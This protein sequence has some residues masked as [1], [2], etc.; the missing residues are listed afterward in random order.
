MTDYIVII[1]Y[2]KY[3]CQVFMYFIIDKTLFVCYSNS[4][5]H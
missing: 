3:Y 1:Y 2:S 4:T 5:V